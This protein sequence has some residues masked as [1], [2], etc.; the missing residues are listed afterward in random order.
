[1]CAFALLAL[2]WLALFSI[3]IF[4]MPLPVFVVSAAAW[5][6]VGGVAR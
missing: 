2:S 6:Q 1:V 3:G 4:L 5:T